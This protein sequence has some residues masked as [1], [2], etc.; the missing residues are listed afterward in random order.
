MNE[1]DTIK[2]GGHFEIIS[3]EKG[4]EV[5]R[6]P[7]ITNR[8]LNAGLAQIIQHHIGNAANALEI[9]SLEI[10][11]GATAV[12]AGDTALANLVLADIPVARNT[13]SA[14]SVVLEFFIVDAE[15]ADGTYRELGL[16]AGAT[17]Y[18]R[19]LFTTPYTKVAGRDTIIR[20]TLSYS[21]V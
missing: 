12:T 8:I 1:L 18:T 6:S 17:L 3:L 4:K 9:T 14:L 10:G 15:L 13:P 7:V 21:A 19:A 5:W 2:A 20:Y 16:R 11:D